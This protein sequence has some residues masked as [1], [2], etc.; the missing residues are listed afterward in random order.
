MLGGRRVGR[1]VGLAGGQSLAGGMPACPA[2]TSACS[3][4][5]RRRPCSCRSTRRQRRRWR[6]QQSAPRQ[7]WRPAVLRTAAAQG[8]CWACR[9]QTSSSRNAP[10]LRPAATPLGCPLAGSRG[11]RGFNCW[12]RPRPLPAPF[13]L[14]PR[15]LP[16]VFACITTPSLLQTN[17]QHRGH[18]KKAIHDE[19]VSPAHKELVDQWARA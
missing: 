15:G 11:A 9:M 8:M 6:R 1:A 16:P 19:K 4:T 10:R 17:W 18:T 12:R 13:L 5:S 14:L 7:R 3:F 2:P